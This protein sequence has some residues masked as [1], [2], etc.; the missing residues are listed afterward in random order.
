MRRW[1]VAIA[2]G[3]VL[4]R[5]APVVNAQNLLPTPLRLSAFAVNMSNIG[6]GATS[7]VTIQ[8]DRWGTAAERERLVNVLVQKGPERLLDALQDT[9]PVGRIWMPGTTGFDLRFAQVDAVGD[10]IHRIVIVTDRP[11]GVRE[12]LNRSRTVD[13]PFTLI[14]IQ[15]DGQNRGDGRMSVATKIT[16]S[17]STNSIILEDIASEPVRLQNVQIER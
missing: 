11:I 2:A 13:Y 10:G 6:T 7:V 4:L 9:R 8:I 14:Q 5:A 17:A 16:Y 15:L 12:A 3:V 1:L